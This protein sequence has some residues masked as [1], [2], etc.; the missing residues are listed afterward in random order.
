MIRNLKLN[1]KVKNIYR[2]GINKEQSKQSHKHN[3]HKMKYKF[4]KVLINNRRSIANKNQK[5]VFAL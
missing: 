3:N 4:Q 2:K 5:N 1:Q